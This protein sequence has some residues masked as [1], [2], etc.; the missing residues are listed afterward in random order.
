MCTT[1]VNIKL[2]LRFLNKIKY[3]GTSDEIK[4]YF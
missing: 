3:L 1:N 4:I 2:I